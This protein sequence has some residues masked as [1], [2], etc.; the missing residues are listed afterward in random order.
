MEG[1]MFEH[2]RQPRFLNREGK[3]FIFRIWLS[4]ILSRGEK[5]FSSCRLHLNTF[6][7]QIFFLFFFPFIFGSNNF[8][9]EKLWK[10]IN[11][12]PFSQLAKFL[13]WDNVTGSD[14]FLKPEYLLT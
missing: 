7:V 4:S 9:E 2:R 8:L 11:L 1:E 14:R 13:V 10:K 3:R 6:I 5:D 12:Q